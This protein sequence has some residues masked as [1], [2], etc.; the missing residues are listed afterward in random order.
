MIDVAQDI[1]P[2]ADYFVVHA[3]HFF[4]SQKMFFKKIE[5]EKNR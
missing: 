3:K 4:K 5:E 2:N 1:I